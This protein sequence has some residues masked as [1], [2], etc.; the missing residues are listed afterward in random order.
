MQNR[1]PAT[2]NT[3]VNGTASTIL[4]ITTSFSRTEC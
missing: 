2:S 3:H 4:G 1:Q